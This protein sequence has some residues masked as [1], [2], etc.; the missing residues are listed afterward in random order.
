[1]KYPLDV[2]L[3][4]RNLRQDKAM[5]NLTKA[6]SRL[7][8]ARRHL[9]DCKK[10]HADYLVWLAEEEERRYESIMEVEMTLGDVDEF[11]QGLCSIRGL[12]AGYLERILRAEKSV[13]DAEE[14]V[15]QAKAALLEAQRATM[16]IEAH[17]SRWAEMARKEEERLEEVEL[18]DFVPA[19][20]ELLAV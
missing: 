8:E 11:K 17:K 16:K 3:D 14:G 6:E 4:V 20:N 18:E 9:R 13:T 1:M 5:G 19:T 12:E 10:K 15:R 2:L 7:A